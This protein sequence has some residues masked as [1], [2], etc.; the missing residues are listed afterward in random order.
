MPVPSSPLPSALTCPPRHAGAPGAAR[1]L[2][3]A[4]AHFGTEGRAGVLD[5]G[6]APLASE[7]KGAGAEEAGGQGRGRAGGARKGGKQGLAAAP[8]LAELGIL[9]GV[10]KLARLSQEARGTPGQGRREENSSSGPSASSLPPLPSFVSHHPLHLLPFS[11]LLTSPCP[12]L[13]FSHSHEVHSLA[14]PLPLRWA[15]AGASVGTGSWE[16]PTLQP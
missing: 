16:T 2:D 4:A 7:A 3:V 13:P 5:L 14:G 9:A 10:R 15:Q 6:L 12:Q 11:F 1:G 8:V